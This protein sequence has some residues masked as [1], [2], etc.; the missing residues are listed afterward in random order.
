MVASVEQDPL[1]VGLFSLAQKRL[2]WADR[3]QQI[4]AENIA[5]A[6]TPGWQPVD[7]QPFSSGLRNSVTSLV[8][9]S[10]GDLPGTTLE[11]P[12]SAVNDFPIARAPDGNAVSLDVQLTKI[13]DTQTTQQFVTEIYKKYLNMFDTALDK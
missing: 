7:V 11:A 9:T 6:D 13:A 1:Q 8:Q 10:S 4:L 2:A 12:S 3:R 5:N